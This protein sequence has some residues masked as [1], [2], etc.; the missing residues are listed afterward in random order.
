[1]VRELHLKL[2]K[3]KPL[4]TLEACS[5]PREPPPPRA[6]RLVACPRRHTLRDGLARVEAGPR[7]GGH[8]SR[9]AVRAGRSIGV[10]IL[11]AGKKLIKQRM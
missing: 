2:L 9:A 11:A 5:V 10:F 4:K 7:P 1:M 8:G 3:K 6:P